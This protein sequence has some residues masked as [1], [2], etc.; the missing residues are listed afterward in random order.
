MIGP[1]PH[2]PLG[3]ADVGGERGFDAQLGFLQVDRTAGIGNGVGRLLG[4]H[5]G[6]ILL[7][8]LC[9]R[10]PLGLRLSLSLVTRSSWHRS[11][12]LLLGLLLRLLGARGSPCIGIGHCAIGLRTG[13]KAGGGAQCE[14]PIELCDQRAARVGPDS[15]K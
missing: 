9:R 15:R 6:S 7:L 11:H 5:L 1:E 14:R 4:R 2:Q 10:L 13:G 8:A 3:E 12:L